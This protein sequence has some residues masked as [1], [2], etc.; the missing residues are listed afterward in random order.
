MKYIFNNKD[1]YLFLKAISVLYASANG[2]TPAFQF[3]L[4]L[5]SLSVLQLLVLTCQAKYIWFPVVQVASSE[6]ME[7]LYLIVSSF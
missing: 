7:N 1:S 4:C 6:R 5:S 2:F 3:S